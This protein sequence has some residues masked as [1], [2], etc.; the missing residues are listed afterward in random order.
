M[1]DGGGEKP[2]V[3]KPSLSYRT[4]RK[5]SQETSPR[6]ADFPTSLTLSKGLEFSLYCMILNI[7]TSDILYEVLIKD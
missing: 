4:L 7:F 1:E 2:G 6:R 5:Y 3:A